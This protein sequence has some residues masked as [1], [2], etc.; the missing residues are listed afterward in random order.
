[1]LRGQAG[2]NAW[3][4]CCSKGRMREL[5]RTNDAVLVS[6]V[7]ALLDGAGIAHLVLDQNMSVL[8][9]SLG[10]LPRRILVPD[11]DARKARR[12]LHDAGLGHEL[13]HDEDVTEDAALAGRVRLRQPR[14]GHRFG[15]D[16]ILLAAATEVRAGEHVVDLGAGIG[17]AGLALAVRSAGVRVT[18]VDA[19]TAL[20][21]LAAENATLNG[22]DGRVRAI[23]LDVRA[24]EQTFAASGLPAGT[25]DGVMMNPPFNDAARQNVSPDAA[26]ASAHRASRDTI[27]TWTATAARLLRSKGRLTLIWRADALDEVLAAFE[28]SFGGVRLLPIHPKPGAP[29]IRV[30]LCAVKD[31]R[32]PLTLLPGFILADAQ[33][34]PTAEVEAVL[35]QALPLAVVEG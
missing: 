31:S 4:R 1:M 21:E 12:L 18:L 32:A 35:R 24:S 29:A 14:R 26:R 30:I 17:A 6:A 2:L 3:R 9:G 22:L 5:V 27:V 8:E 20:V 19:D 25:A 34:R 15:H 7:G 11:E 33:G 28:R 10:I 16:A 13:R 23:A